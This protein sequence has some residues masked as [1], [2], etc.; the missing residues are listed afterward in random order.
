MQ[1]DASI[2]KIE[3]NAA[4]YARRIEGHSINAIAREFGLARETVRGI[5]RRMQRKATWRAIAASAAA[6]RC[7]RISGGLD[8]A[9]P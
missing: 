2:S 5:A 9:F 6:D 1:T 8:S 3:R 7:R 4:I